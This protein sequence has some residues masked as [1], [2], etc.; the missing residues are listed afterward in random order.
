MQLDRI[1]YRLRR[2]NRSMIIAILR[3][4]RG[5][6]F[7]LLRAFAAAYTDGYRGLPLLLVIFL[8]GFGCRRCGCRDCRAT[9]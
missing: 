3:T 5:P 9:P 4:L 7:F 6:V 2:S 8:L 1:R